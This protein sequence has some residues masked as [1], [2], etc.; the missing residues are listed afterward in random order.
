MEAQAFLTSIPLV[1]VLTFFLRDPTPLQGPADSSPPSFTETA[2]RGDAESCAGLSTPCTLCVCPYL[3][4]VV[5]IVFTFA[6]C[7]AS[8]FVVRQARTVVINHKQ[9]Q[10]IVTLQE[11]TACALLMDT[12]L[13]VVSTFVAIG[14]WAHL[15]LAT[16]EVYLALVAAGTV[17]FVLALKPTYDTSMALHFQMPPNVFAQDIENQEA[18]EMILMSDNVLY[19]HAAVDDGSKGKRPMD[20]PKRLSSS[21]SS[22]SDADVVS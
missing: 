7:V 22:S 10:R 15:F 17:T 12:A 2:H 6:Y 18:Q 21:S 14:G 3:S 11:V 5:S 13:R 4:V 1:L 20:E 9:M 19:E 8:F 16:A